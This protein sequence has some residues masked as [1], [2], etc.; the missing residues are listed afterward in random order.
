[1]EVRLVA[2]L[3]VDPVAAAHAHRPLEAVL[4]R[5]A[6]ELAEELL[7]LPHAVGAQV[8]YSQ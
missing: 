7:P 2:R 3:R 5:E 8:P 1:M 4:Q 6:H